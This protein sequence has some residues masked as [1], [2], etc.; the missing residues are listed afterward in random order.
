M[1]TG[2]ADSPDEKSNFHSSRPCSCD[3]PAPVSSPGPAPGVNTARSVGTVLAALVLWGLAYAALAPGSQWLAHDLLGLGA[4]T[5]WGDAVEF[6]LYDT[7]KIL[8]LLVLMVYVLAWLRAGLRVERVRD[9][10]AGRGRSVGYLLGA[11][12]GAVTPFCSCSSIPLFMGFTTA[13]IP[14]GMT[15][16]FLITS[17]LIN[18]IAVVLL[19]GLLGW[20]FT[21]VYV[22]VGLLAGVAGGVIMDAVHA[23]RWLQPFLLDAVNNSPARTADIRTGKV[24]A[25]SLR[26]RHAFALSETRHIFRRVRLWVLIGV[27]LGAA[28]HGFVP[29]EWFAEHLGA[30]QWWSVPAAV[31]V[32]IPLY[33]NVTGIVP[34]MESL[35]LKG[36]PLGTT[37]AF[38]MST[39][40][41]SL[42][43]VLMLKQVMRWKLLTVFLGVLLILFTLVGWLFNLLQA[44]IL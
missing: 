19:W 10:L 5:P 41:A 22:L 28:L 42:P 33:T 9:Y 15:L 23:E 20:K 25:L 3:R 2:R 21:L 38:C 39:V 35:L 29:Q 4:G 7:A 32:G 27:G 43:E 6:F 13:R 17:P 1:S 26:E 24:S 44:F 31:A 37:L 34:V 18:E 11:G 40:A 12:F 16:A 30:G 36:L 14:V 8:L